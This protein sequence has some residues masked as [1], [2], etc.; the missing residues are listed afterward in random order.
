MCCTRRM[1]P[2]RKY[3]NEETGDCQAYAYCSAKHAWN[4][5]WSHRHIRILLMSK[6]SMADLWHFSRSYILIHTITKGSCALCATGSEESSA[7]LWTFNNK[8][9]E[10]QL[11]ERRAK[12]KSALFDVR[13]THVD[14]NEIY[15]KNFDKI[16]ASCDSARCHNLRMDLPVPLTNEA[17]IHRLVDDILAYIFV[18]NATAP[19]PDFCEHAMTV[20]SSGFFPSL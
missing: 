14:G 13:K 10:I 17:A 2:R 3:W 7:L 5:S 11:W 8:I 18:L 19:D 6:A 1:T 12:G 16:D 15:E 9:I 4:P 20:A